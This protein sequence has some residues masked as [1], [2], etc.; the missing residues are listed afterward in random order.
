MSTQSFNFV[1]HGELL[2]IA[3]LAPDAAVPSWARGRFL[4]IART[5][6][7]LSIVCAQE[8]VPPQTVHERERIAL[9]IQG[10]VAM[11]TVGVL[12]AL[13]GAL[14]AARVPVFVISTY[15]TDWILVT[16][17]RF[18]SARAALEAAGHTVAGDAP[19]K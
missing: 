4:N 18:A 19:R 16:A 15:D 9:G 14:A 11:T 17:E 7:E 12:A 1:V 8:Q 6:S 2:A 10:V 13:C 5:P 3:R